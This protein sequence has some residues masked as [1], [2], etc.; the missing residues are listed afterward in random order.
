MSANKGV[1]SI[2]LHNGMSFEERLAAWEAPSGR[3]DPVD[4]VLQAEKGRMSELPLLRH[5]PADSAKAV[6]TSGGPSCLR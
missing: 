4:L 1:G 6:S 3:P 5:A 2:E